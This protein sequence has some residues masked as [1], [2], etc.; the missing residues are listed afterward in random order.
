MGSARHF[1][2]GA[3]VA[4]AE[5]DER[6]ARWQLTL[7]DGGTLQAHA[8]VSAV[9]Q[10]GRPR[11]PDIPGRDSFGG[12]SW[13]SARWDHGV[14]L[15]GQRV[16]VLGT[17]ASAIQFV[18]EIA[19]TAG[20]VNVF[21]RNAPYILP[22]SDRAYQPGELALYDRL[23]V[24]RKADRLR[25]FLYG[26]LLTSGFVI[27]PRLQAAPM[28]M[29]RRQLRAISDPELRAKCIPDYRLGCKRVLFSDDWYPTLTRPNVE[30]VTDPIERIAPGGVVTAGGATR[31]ADVLVY[32]TGFHSHD[33]LAPM[34]VTGRAAASC[35]PNGT[36]APRRTLASRCPGSRTSSCC[37][38]RTPTSAAT[39]SSTCW[40]ARSS[41]C[42][43]PCGRLT[44]PGSTGWTY[45]PRCSGRSINGW[46]G[47][48]GPRCGRADAR[49]GTPCLGAQHQ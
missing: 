16:A 7:E 11:L 18:P 10:L 27:S 4:A 45:G 32:G 33:F 22:K 13:H 2:F 8:V 38:G 48:A 6:R 24:L 25:I 39:R 17:G 20:H 19:K 43:A 46:C 26:E 12:P 3:G 47:P 35:R 49:A 40:K 1:R 21:Q 14:D 37:M 29:W 5:F 15:A 36:T 9:G 44:R 31:P 41:T 30:L 42:S 23:P 34:A 28:A